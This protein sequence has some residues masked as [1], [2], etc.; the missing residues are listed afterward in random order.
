N[1]LELLPRGDK[2]GRHS[3]ISDGRCV[4][5]H[6]NAEMP[7]KDLCQASACDAGGGFSGA[8]TFKNVARIGV[9]ILQ[10]SGKV[11]M[12]G[13]RTFDSTL[14][15]ATVGY[16][17]DRHDLLPVRPIAILDHHGNRTADALPIPN[18]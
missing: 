15:R 16:L 7:E 8:G 2:F 3:R 11:R 13:P 18:T 9:V 14:G 4:A 10:R 5:K 12:P 17:A 6:F 1:C